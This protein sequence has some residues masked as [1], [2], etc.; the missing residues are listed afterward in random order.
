MIRSNRGD[1]KISAFLIAVVIFGVV[2]AGSDYIYSEYSQSYDLDD[3][4]NFRGELQKQD[5]ASLLSNE[6]NDQLTLG[7]TAGDEAQD[8]SVG[9]TWGVG[10]LALTQGQG[11][12]VNI[13]N[14]LFEQFNIAELTWAKVGLITI[15]ALLFIF[16]IMNIFFK[17]KT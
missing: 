15:L 14:G 5:N 13:I 9:A 4:P 6:M 17:V 16:A 12:G 10:M 11:Y 3:S 2:I 8:A 7:G 1:F